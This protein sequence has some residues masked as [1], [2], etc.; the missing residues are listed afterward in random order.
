MALFRDSELANY[1]SLQAHH[2]IDTAKTGK[3]YWSESLGN[4]Y[5]WSDISA[6]LAYSQIRRLEVL[7][8]ERRK[9]FFEYEKLLSGHGEKIQLQSQLLNINQVYWLPYFLSNRFADPIVKKLFFSKALEK[10]ISFRPLFYPLVEMPP[11]SPFVGGV[12][13]E[14]EL[15]KKFPNSFLLSSLGVSLP[16]GAYL[17]EKSVNEVSKFII[18]FM[19]TQ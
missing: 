6:A 15:K 7:V 16:T 11:F 2:G 10:D 8:A 13:S 5:A 3:Y 17:D 9:I 18:D 12:K 14:D 19:K 1:V 4:N